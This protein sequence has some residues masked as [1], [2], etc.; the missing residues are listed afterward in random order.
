[1]PAP[2]NAEPAAAGRSDLC[3]C[4]WYAMPETDKANDAIPATESKTEP[5]EPEHPIAEPEKKFSRWVSAKHAKE[6]VKQAAEEACRAGGSQNGSA[7]K[8]VVKKRTKP[9]RDDSD[10]DKEEDDDDND[11]DYSDDGEREKKKRKVGRIKKRS[12]DDDSETPDDD[13]SSGEEFTPGQWTSPVG[14]GSAVPD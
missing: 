7:K 10:E 14:A 1:M 6:E 2:S 13:E 3:L 4:R 5:A 12:R 9:A 8:V 11:D